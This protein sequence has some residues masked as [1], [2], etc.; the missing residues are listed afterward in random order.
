M[1]RFVLS[2]IGTSILT[3]QIYGDK[4]IANGDRQK[5]Q[6]LMKKSANCKPGELDA[7]AQTVLDTL[8]NW[9]LEKLQQGN[10]QQNRGISAELNGIYGIY[11]GRLPED[12]PDEHY[13]ICTDTAQGQK[14]GELIKDFLVTHGVQNVE[15]VI[16]KGLSM[17]D[18]HS[19]TAGTK[20]LIRW[21]EENVQWRRDSKSY[22][23]IFNLVGG[24]KSLQG[25]MNTFGTF[26]SDEMIYIFDSPTSSLIRIPRLPI[27]IDTSAIQAH[28]T[29][30][31]LMVAGQ[32]YLRDELRIPDTWLELV[33]DEGETYAGLSAWGTLVYHR[34]KADLLAEE[35]LQFP[36]L[37]YKQTF[38]QDFDNENNDKARVRL[39]ET[40]AKI[41]CI[42]QENKGIAA[43]RVDNALDFKELQGQATG[44]YSFRISKSIRVRCTIDKKGLVLR[45]YVKK[46]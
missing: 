7:E 19:F 30:F 31:A 16:P 20:E 2:T 28:R 15:I 37:E 39:Q 24:F 27:Q 42:L 17:E 35:L 23:V 3:N 13:L 11:N 45:D 26:Y 6:N 25:Y 34:S 10:T 44:I 46:V 40:L 22:H 4:R 29:E 5:W 21:L 9:A 41:S 36:L 12:S 1:T 38:Q 14:T 33:E 43:L 18:T 32:L 8:A